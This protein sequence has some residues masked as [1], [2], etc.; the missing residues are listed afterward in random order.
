MTSQSTFYDFLDKHN[1]KNTGGKTFTHTRIPKPELNIYA[2]S[3]NIPDEKLA[4]FHKSYY[5]HIFVEKKKEYLTEKQLEIGGP[6]VVD[7]DF[8]Y[9]NTVNTRQHSNNHV[10]DIVGCYLEELKN[11]YDFQEGDKFPVFV[12]EKP[13]VNLFDGTLTKDGIHMIFDLQV[14]HAIQCEIRNA[15]LKPGSTFSF[16]MEELPLINTLESVLD[17]G[18]SKGTTNWQ[19]YGSRK[20]G[21]DAYELTHHYE[22]TFNEDNEF[23]IN[24]QKV[25]DFNFKD[26]FHLLSVQN[27]NNLKVELKEQWKTKATT[28]SIKK[29]TQKS[30]SSSSIS[31]TSVASIDVN[32]DVP[33]NESDIYYKYLNCIGR[34]MCGKGQ[35][36]ETIQVLQILKNEQLDIKYVEYWIHRYAMPD[37]K[38]YTY[39]ISHYQDHIKYRPLNE[40][41]RLTLKTLKMLARQKNPELYSKY[42]TDDYEFMFKKKYNI[43]NMK[44]NY[45]DEK[46]FRDLYYEM[47]KDKII[48][49]NECIYFYDKDEWNVMD[50][51]GRMVKNDMLNLFDIYVKCCFDILNDEKKKSTNDPEKLKE[52]QETDKCICSMNSS[53]KKNLY[54]NNIFN[55]LLNELAS[56]KTNVVFDI[57]SDNHYNVHFKNGVYDLK[58][59]KFRSRTQ[60]DYVTQMLNYDYVE[61]EFISQ[62]IRDNIMD[63]FK[64]IQPDEDQRKFTLSYL[65]YCLSGDT[66]Q[67]VFKINIGHTASNGKS[68]EIKIHNKCFPE[69]TLKSDKRVLINNFDKRHKFLI[70]LEKKPIRLLYFEEMP[71]ASKLDNAFIKEWVDGE[72]F[73]VEV[74]F[75]TNAEIK[76]QSK[77]MA[78]SNYDFDCDAD[79][80]ILRRGLLQFYT[81]KFVNEN[82][83]EGAIDEE[84]HV[85]KKVRDYEKTFEDNLYKNAYFHLLL[86]YTKELYIPKKNQDDFKATAQS[87]DDVVE[88]ILEKFTITKLETDK[89]GKCV[90]MADIGDSKFKDYKDALQSL[91]CKY[92]SQ[93]KYYDEVDKKYKSGVFCGLKL[94]S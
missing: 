22:I 94:I 2:G 91:G 10:I 21:N 60:Y 5:H 49:K 36:S 34:T 65:A 6:M 23:N 1:N 64:K 59:G 43:E 39:A 4:L 42:F 38:K 28:L 9:A 77:L 58:I 48:Y 40:E 17:E 56:V 53:I 12:M 30:S 18:I 70:E 76:N 13:K 32:T 79:A 57:G 84:N 71:K 88:T 63:F 90:L 86:E 66:S 93:E 85:Y 54:I 83:S 37:S 46:A 44:T 29:T 69:Y 80:G 19:L 25:S 75:G 31:P 67:Q 16:I 7:F 61:K 47:K 62:E 3:Y 73:K 92:K 14:P 33:L 41:R 55:L 11:M 26:N 74:M 27:K 51:K 87:G 52:L 82:G 35:H 68:T 78:V 72:G 45:K 50:E 20:P 15:M 81:S 89:I 24:E 8:R